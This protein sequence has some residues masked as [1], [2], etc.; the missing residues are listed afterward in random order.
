[1]IDSP[2]AGRIDSAVGDPAEILPPHEHERIWAIQKTLDFPRYIFGG[3]RW[4]LFRARTGFMHR[5]PVS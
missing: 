1:M 3:R 2:A 5:G 4:Q